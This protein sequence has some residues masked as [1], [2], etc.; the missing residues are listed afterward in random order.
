MPPPGGRPE[1]ITRNFSLARESRDITVPIGISSTA[2][3]YGTP[4]SDLI[5]ESHPLLPIN[6]YG[7]SKLAGER[8]VQ[9]AGGAHLIL[10]TAWVY[11]AHGANFVK[12]SM[13]KNEPMF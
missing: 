10:R 8:A 7:A 3:V 11:S 9:A 5:A 4:Q 2:A 6:P 13:P 1:S 12:T